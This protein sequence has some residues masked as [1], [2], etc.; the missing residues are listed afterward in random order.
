MITHNRRAEALRSVGRLLAL[1]ERPL[2]PESG[3]ARKV[4]P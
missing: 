3:R 1:P 2:P 4:A